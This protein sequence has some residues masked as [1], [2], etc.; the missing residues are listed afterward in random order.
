MINARIEDFDEVIDAPILIAGSGIAGNTI[1]LGCQ[2][3]GVHMLTRKSLWVG[4]SS[5]W[6]QGGIAAAVGSNDSPQL[7]AQD[8]IAAGAGLTDSEVAS[9]LTEQAA[10]AVELLR[11]MGAQFDLNEFGQ[12]ELAREAAHQR[13]RVLHANKDATGAELMRAL[14]TA[15]HNT[16][17]IHVHDETLAVDL[18]LDDSRRVIGVVGKQEHKLILFRTKAVVL[19]TG[20]IGQMYRYTTNPP[21]ARGEGIAMAARAGARLTDLEFVQ[22]H[23]TAMLVAQDPLPLITEAMRGAGAFLVDETGHRFMPD[24]H[25]LAEL[26]PRDVVAR[27]VW[28]QMSAGHKV[29]I[30]PR[31]AIGDQFEDKFPNIFEECKKWN[32]DPRTQPI[33]VV[34]AAHYHMGGIDVSL[35]GRAT[36]PG[37][38]ACGEVSSTGVHGAN[39]LASNSLL[40]AVVFGN[41]V[42]GDI[43]STDLARLHNGDNYVPYTVTEMREMIKPETPHAE[44][45]TMRTIMW[46]SVGLIREEAGLWHAIREF[47]LFLQQYDKKNYAVVNRA[48]VCRMLAESALARCE[49]R[50]AH[51]RTDYPDTSTEF[52]RHSMAQWDHDTKSCLVGFEGP[53]AGGR[54]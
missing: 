2:H 43:T 7:H 54:S 41:R 28:A 33:P 8:T 21:E 6:A 13:P 22:F 11:R 51:Y 47:E 50:G 10:A 36:I 18:V 32:I 16:P 30:D 31:E 9:V 34:P 49:S 53:A 12:F 39:R 24:V 29:F 17:A 38:W 52:R 19:A 40:E 3:L 42:V 48:L 44:A 26:A 37:L 23:P 45:A 1:A 35:N 25:P 14:A 20:G 15:V 5:F 4:G 46:D 27:G